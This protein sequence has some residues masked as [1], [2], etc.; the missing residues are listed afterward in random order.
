MTSVKHHLRRIFSAK[1][2]AK[3]IA[4]KIPPRKP[5]LCARKH[6][7]SRRESFSIVEPDRYPVYDAA[8]LDYTNLR[9]ILGFTFQAISSTSETHCHRCV[10][11]GG[12]E[13]HKVV[14][15]TWEK[16]PCFGWSW[17]SFLLTSCFLILK[18]HVG[19][20]R[21]LKIV[22]WNEMLARLQSFNG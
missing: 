12:P 14:G 21:F 11:D 10:G 3:D 8:Q 19:W 9:L 6:R 17:R 2:A 15:K 13:E 16:P 4:K 22:G 20:W 7:E 5:K 1:A 18:L